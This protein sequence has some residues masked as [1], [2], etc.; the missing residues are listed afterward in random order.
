MLEPKTPLRG[1]ELDTFSS[2][3]VFLLGSRDFAYI[4]RVRRNRASQKQ[5]F[6]AAGLNYGML[7]FTKI[8]LK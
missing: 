1:L 6:G 8:Y 2:L 7:N 5:Y 4:Y 3:L